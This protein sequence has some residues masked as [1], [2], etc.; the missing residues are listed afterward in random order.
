MCVCLLFSGYDDKISKNKA[1][2][3]DAISK[4]S[5]INATIK[6]AVDTNA[7]TTSV[8]DSVDTPYNEA[9]ATA[10]SLEQIVTRLEVRETGWD[11]RT[12]TRS[13]SYANRQLV[14][15]PR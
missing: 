6:G 12:P 2:A 15:G 1:L 8:L 7:E 3:D 5:A 4:L 10:G 13:S 14:P 9:L 11:M